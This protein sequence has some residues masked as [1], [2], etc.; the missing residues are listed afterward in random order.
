VNGIRPRVQRIDVARMAGVSPTTVT[1]VMNG[2]TRVSIPEETR[3]RVRRVA[4]ELGYRP[5]R[6]AAALRTGRMNIIGVWLGCRE[7]FDNGVI[8]QLSELLAE[9]GFEMLLTT[10]DQGTGWRAHLERLAECPV[11]GIV[12][13]DLPQYIDAYISDYDPHCRPVVGLGTGS[14]AAVDRVLF[15]VS[16][17]GAAAIKHLLEIGCRRITFLT[18]DDA[19][20][21]KE[22][23]YAAYLATMQEAGLVPSVTVA[24]CLPGWRNRIHAWRHMKGHLAAVEMP[25]AIAC[26]NDDLAI[27][28][29]RAA[30]DLGLRVPDD[31]TSPLCQDIFSRGLS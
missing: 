2:N 7:A 14:S 8:D 31:Y 20:D 9:S 25:D 19:N 26:F 23:R 4:E 29:L 15:D 28:T 27:G 21:P 16:N 24:Q 17:G 18:R 22:P 13:I 6:I 12:A 30:L 3:A 10:A 1:F 5:S 11:D